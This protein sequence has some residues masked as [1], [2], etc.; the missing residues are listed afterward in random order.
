MLLVPEAGSAG[1][2]SWWPY[3]A[4][5]TSRGF[6]VLA[7]DHRCQG[8]S[9]CPAGGPG[10][11]LLADIAAA[12]QALRMAGADRV[13]LLGASQGGS[14][15]GSCSLRSV[16]QLRVNGCWSSQPAR[17]TDGRWSPRHRAT[18]GRHWPPSLPVSS[19]R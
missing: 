9:A 4:Y 14:E 12:A 15:V 18:T 17:T 10:E 3:A 2:C 1:S 8:A 6:H 5:L 11:G 7:F 16:H 13:A 19:S